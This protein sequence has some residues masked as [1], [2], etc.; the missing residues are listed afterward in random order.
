MALRG[1]EMEDSNR[2]RSV[3]ACLYHWEKTRP[4]AVHFTQP[5][6]SGV[7]LEYTW[8]RILDEVRRMATHLVA[9]D[10]PPRSNIALLGKNSAHW[11][12]ADWAIWMAGHVS[13]PLYPTSSAETVRYVL[14]HSESRLLFVGR[15]DDWETMRAGV[16]S[17]LPVIRLPLAPLTD[18]ERWDAIIGRTRPLEGEPDR[19]LDELATIVYTSGSTGHPKGVMQSFRAFNVIGARMPN[20]TGLRPDDRMLSYLPLAHVAERVA[21]QTQSTYYGFQVFFAN[22]LDTF[23]DDLRRARP[24][25]FFSVP[26][27]WTK[28]QLGVRTK[29]SERKEAVL[30]R[31][32]FVG[33][34]I[35]KKILAQLGLADVRLAL[36]GAAPLPPE[37]L[38]WYRELGLELLEGYG[39]SENMAYSHLT[40]LGEARAGYV[41]HA[42]DGVECKIGEG[43]EVLVKSPAQMMGY[44]KQPELT[45]GCYTHDGFFKTG[46]MGEIDAQG[47]LRITG[48]VKDLFKTSK[49][50]YVAPVPIENRLG[51]HALVESALV[52]GANQTAPFAVLVLSEE[53][54]S[55]LSSGSSRE[56]VTAEIEALLARVNEPADPHERL[57]FAVVAA[58]SWTVDNGL[59]TPTLKIRR[60]VLERHYE[61]EVAGWFAERRS[62]IFQAEASLKA[63]GAGAESPS[64]VSRRVSNS[65]ATPG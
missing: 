23:L 54:R 55:A 21:V 48:R 53:T 20:T 28:F 29:L 40:K 4:D 45:A 9:L 42:N 27:L 26:R 64:E 51:A 63:R 44:Y 34:R 47:R 35:K 24:T 36:T 10:L 7:V 14:E 6:P 16:P 3:L 30:F 61:P 46:D 65:D 41:G 49:G 11:I 52:A 18:G 5:T 33:R 31:V 17:A 56:A 8:R 50:K 19:A 32:P 25:I 1:E 58:E 37:I 39:M 62:V 59:L 22:S 43:G 57:A 12:M 60:T 15:L 2:D 13:V 38:T